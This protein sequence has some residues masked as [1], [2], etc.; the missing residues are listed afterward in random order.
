MPSQAVKRES[1]VVLHAA[2]LPDEPIDEELVVSRHRRLTVN[3]RREEQDGNDL[4]T[5]RSGIR[6]EYFRY[7]WSSGQRYLHPKPAGRVDW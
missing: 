2:F 3:V 7:S 1:S 6:N 5:T 4:K